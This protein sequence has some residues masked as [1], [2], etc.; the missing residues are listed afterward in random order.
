VL[1]VFGGGQVVDERGGEVV[2]GRGR[3]PACGS[4]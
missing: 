3:S 1:L 4:W 2:R